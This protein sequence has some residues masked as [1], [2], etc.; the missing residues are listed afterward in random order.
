MRTD[1]DTFIKNLK[2]LVRSRGVKGTSF[3][4]GVTRFSVRR[5]L[6]KSRRPS[7]RHYEQVLRLSEVS[8]DLWKDSLALFWTHDWASVNKKRELYLATA[9]QALVSGALFEEKI[10]NELRQE[11]GRRP[12]IF[13]PACSGLV[14]FY[15]DTGEKPHF[16]LSAEGF[17][18]KR[19]TAD[20]AGMSDLVIYFR[21]ATKATPCAHPPQ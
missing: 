1:I 21:L 4:L 15:R 3:A 2:S 5:W 17:G 8:Y 12:F 10:E 18:R 16:D 19:V 11:Q 9:I 7:G 13:V 20:P 14:K 6:N